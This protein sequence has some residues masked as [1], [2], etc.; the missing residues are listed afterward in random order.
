M[1]GS[2]TKIIIVIFTKCRTSFICNIFK[3]V[4]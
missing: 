3:E 1:E 4:I 2:T